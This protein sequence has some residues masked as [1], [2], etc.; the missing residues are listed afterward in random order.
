MYCERGND[1]AEGLRRLL[2]R[3]QLRVI[4]VV[5]A[6][7]DMGATSVVVN[8]AAALAG[9]GK[10][11][12]VLDENGGHDNVA[13]SLGL[14]PRYDLMNTVRDG[15]NWRDVM[16]HGANGIHVLPVAK[17]MQALPA[18]DGAESGSLLQ[19]LN[20]ASCG[21]DVVLVDA[22]TEHYSVCA[23]LSGGEPLLLVFNATAEGITET[24]TLL[25]QMVA[26]Y[27]RKTF[28]LV[29]NKARNTAEASRA[30]DN[31]AQVAQRHLGVT[32]KYMGYIPHDEQFAAAEKLRTTLPAQTSVAQAFAA[33]AQRLLPAAQTHSHTLQH[34]MQRLLQQRPPMLKRRPV[35]HMDQVIR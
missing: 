10:Q 30:F 2:L 28:D 25:K 16:L 35:A 24:Y 14:K 9:E 6:R 31:M 12:M 18:L 11:V 34:L 5:G 3:P 19:N 33:L 13:N 1:Q 4:T 20:A 29:V 15:L 32:L 27:G 7:R 23:S 21:M 26:Q 17:A 22:T 8:L